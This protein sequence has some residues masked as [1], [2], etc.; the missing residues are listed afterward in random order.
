MFD[1]AEMALR[2]SYIGSSDAESPCQIWPG[3]KD[4][5]GYGKKWSPTLKRMVNAHRAIYEEAFG[6]VSIGWDVDHLCRNHSCVNIAHLEAVPRSINLRRGI[7]H[8]RNK[9]HCDHGHAF[10]PEN[11]YIRANGNRDCREC[12]N[13]RSQRHK[14]RKRG[15]PPRFNIYKTSCPAGHPYSVENTYIWINEKGGKERRCRICQGCAN[16]ASRRKASK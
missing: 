11:T 10:T 12:R 6:A 3:G 13:V 1:A 16:R 5:K 8:Q 14:E 15:G 9:T 7:S 2:R 4:K